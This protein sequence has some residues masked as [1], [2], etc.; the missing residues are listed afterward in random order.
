MKDVLDIFIMYFGKAS[1]LYK[2]SLSH[3][4]PLINK[5]IEF[6]ISVRDDSKLNTLFKQIK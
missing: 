6:S 3:P 2:E 5:L 1:V 4:F